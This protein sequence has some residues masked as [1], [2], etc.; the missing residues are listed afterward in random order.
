MLETIKKELSSFKKI[1]KKNKYVIIF[2]IIAFSLII[3]DSLFFEKE[4]NVPSQN[5]F[6]SPNQFLNFLTIAGIILGI[7]AVIP[8]KKI[9]NVFCNLIVFFTCF[10]IFISFLFI[11]NLTTILMTIFFI[12]LIVYFW[13]HANKEKSG[14]KWF[15]GLL[16]LGIAYIISGIT[17]NACSYVITGMEEKVSIPYN[18][19]LNITGF[20]G[21][22]YDFPA[23]PCTI[24]SIKII[25]NPENYQIFPEIHRDELVVLIY[26]KN[27]ITQPYKTVF[28]K[29]GE[30][31][32]LCCFRWQLI[33]KKS[34]IT[35]W[36]PYNMFDIFC[37]LQN[38]LYVKGVYRT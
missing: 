28:I 4:K 36:K 27:N 13:Y 5:M 1:I 34:D 25:E 31:L 24:N 32:T 10:L 2:Y 18:T 6:C 22:T 23:I 11:Y 33:E 15:I 29:E 14:K 37:R 38:V 12:S 16:L 8:N 20:P 26:E 30:Q 19:F 7:F 9:P 21:E 17:G 3:L 35:I